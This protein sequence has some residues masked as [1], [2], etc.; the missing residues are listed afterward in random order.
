MK[1][2]DVSVSEGK[3]KNQ[4]VSVI[5]NRI[6]VFQGLKITQYF[7]PTKENESW[8]ELLFLLAAATRI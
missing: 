4:C 3:K 2:M 8:K 1:Y 6:I 5:G 7:L